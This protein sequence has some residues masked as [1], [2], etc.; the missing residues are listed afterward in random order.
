MVK[1][2][3]VIVVTILGHIVGCYEKDFSTL[4]L[5]YSVISGVI[6]FFSYDFS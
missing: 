3:G 2:I 1:V 4:I 6:T 5:K